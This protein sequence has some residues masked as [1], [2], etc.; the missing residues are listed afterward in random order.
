[1]CLFSTQ[2]PRPNVYESVPFEDGDFCQKKVVFV[3]KENTMMGDGAIFES[4]SLKGDNRI[5]F[6]EACKCTC[7]CVAVSM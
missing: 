2:S 5:V 3:L 4:A 1:M 6:M 7:V